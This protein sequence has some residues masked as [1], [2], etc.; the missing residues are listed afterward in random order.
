MPPPSDSTSPSD[1]PVRPENILYGVEDRPPLLVSLQLTL[2]HISVASASFF[3]VAVFGREIGLSEDD[4]G[5]LIR[6]AMVTMG[7]AA[8]LQ[9]VPRGPL[10]SRRFCPACSG[11]AYLSASLL[12]ARAG[13]MP[14]LC[15]M[16]LIVGVFELIASRFLARLRALFPPEVIGVVVL[17]VGFEVIVVSIPRFAGCTDGR[18]SPDARSILVAALALAAMV[19]PAALS[20]GRLRL[21]ALLIGVAVGYVASWI[22]GLIPAENFEHMASA[23]WFALPEFCHFGWKFEAALLVPFLLAALSS[24]LKGVGDFATAQRIADAR[25]TAPDM[26]AA[27]RGVLSLG[28]S[29][30]LVGFLGGMGMSTA[31]SNV[32]LSLST[33]AVSRI[34]LI[35]LGVG[36]LALAFLPK[37]AAV[38]VLMPEPVLGAALIFAQAFMI[39]AGLQLIRVG[40]TDVRRTLV[41]G[42]ALAFSL[43]VDTMPWLYRGLPGWLAPFFVSSLSLATILAVLLSLLF[44]IGEKPDSA[45]KR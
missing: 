31:S 2:Q 22:A 39:V 36:L 11:P 9:A 17:M 1:T 45:L 7:I 12:A 16:M 14:L 10:G 24:T 15:G 4:V 20:R 32:G 43:S 27:G 3:L 25:W 8:I 42:L 34:L 28:I 30:L 41:V 33:G 38:Y 6:L 44:R 13:G 18:G 23:P 35:F 21:Y 37:I 29:N 26:P 19:L 5:V 40:I